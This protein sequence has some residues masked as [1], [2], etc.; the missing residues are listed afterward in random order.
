VRGNRITMPEAGNVFGD[1]HLDGTVRRRTSRQY[2][3]HRR[4][5]GIHY[6]QQLEAVRIPQDSWLLGGC[7]A[8]S[9]EQCA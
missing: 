5:A 9:G 3:A 2:D 7:T 6:R 8:G 1:E 4:L